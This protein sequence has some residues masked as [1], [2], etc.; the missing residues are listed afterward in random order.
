MM[1]TFNFV[2]DCEHCGGDAYQGMLSSTNEI[3]VEFLTDTPFECEDCKEETVI[4]I[5][6][7]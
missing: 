4:T 6:K 2:I 1:H 5:E 7:Y 3:I